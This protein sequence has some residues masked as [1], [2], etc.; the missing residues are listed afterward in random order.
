MK[1]NPEQLL[2]LAV[3]AAESKKASNLVALDL[4]GVSMI[5]DYFVICH[6]NSDTQVQA[7]ASEIRKV[8]HDAKAEIRG[9]EGVNAARWVLMDLGDVVVHIFHRD[10]REYYNIERLWSDAKV[11]E[12]V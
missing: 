1:L 10:E 2:Q 6:G 11:M 3:E 5:A 7:I 4:R 8:M 12:N 9:M